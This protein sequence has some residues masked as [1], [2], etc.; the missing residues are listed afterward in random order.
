MLLAVRLGHPGQSLRRR[1]RTLAQDAR[2]GAGQIQHRRRRAGHVTHVEDGGDPVEDHLECRRLDV[3]RCLRA[4]SRSS[5]Q[6]R[7]RVRAGRPPDRRDRER[8]RRSCPAAPLPAR[9]IGAQDSRRPAYTGRRGRAARQLRNQL[10]ERVDT[11]ATSAIGCSAE[12]RLSTDS[13]RTASSRP[14]GTRGRTR[15]RSG[16]RRADRRRSLRQPHRPSHGA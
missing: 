16:S 5:R 3:D 4:S 6:R 14:D 11:V 10:H 9:G 15:C 12:R 8:A 1:H 13:A 2:L 7:R